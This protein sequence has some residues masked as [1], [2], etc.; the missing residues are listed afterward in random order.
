MVVRPETGRLPRFAYRLPLSRARL[1][2][3]EEVPIFLAFFHL[4]SV[5]RYKPH[6]LDKVLD[7]PFHPFLLA[8]E[9]HVSAK[10]GLLALDAL[11]RRTHLIS[12]H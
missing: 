10:I 9:R 11:Y 2:L 3:P 6:F 4:G 8:T 7:S 1:L 12:G 5:V